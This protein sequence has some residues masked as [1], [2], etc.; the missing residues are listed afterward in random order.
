LDKVAVVE[1]CSMLKTV[2]SCCELYIAC[3]ALSA[4]I[5]VHMTKAA[6]ATRVQVRTFVLY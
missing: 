6:A 5:N 4:V 3:L 2:V 1:V